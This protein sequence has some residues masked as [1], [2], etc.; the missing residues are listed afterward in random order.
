MSE[1]IRRI[2][3][4]ATL[5]G[6]IAAPSDKSVS[7]RAALFATLYEGVSILTNYSVAEDPQ[8]TLQCIRD[9]GF[10]VETQ[11]QD[12]DGGDTGGV[13]VRITGEGR[14]GWRRRA[15]GRRFELDCGNSGTT[16]R[17]LSGLIAGAGVRCVLTGDASLSRRPM[18][19]ILKPLHDLGASIQAREGRYAPLECISGVKEDSAPS[20]AMDASPLAQEREAPRA[21][22][23]AIASAQ[24][25]SCIL[26]A[27]LFS[28]RGVSVSEPVQSRDHTERMLGI[29][30]QE[31]GALQADSTTS[32]PCQ[33]MRIP[34]DIS[35]AAFWLVAGAV[36][37]DADICVRDCGLN[38]T[39]SGILTV[40]QQ[41]GAELEMDQD[42]TETREPIGSVRVRSSRLKPIHLKGA[43]IPNII[44]E[45]PVIMTA[46]CF[47]D[48]IS[49]ISDAA[50][51][52]VKETDRIAAMCA[53][54]RKA[55]ATI[56]EKP[57]GVVIV[58][59]RDFRP[60]LAP[61]ELFDSEHDHRIAMSCGI[62]SLC[63]GDDGGQIQEGAVGDRGGAETETPRSR[64]EFGILR[65]EAAAV[66]YPEF[67]AHLDSLRA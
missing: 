10:Q 8:S 7:H 53:N 44:D 5:R 66:S 4:A 29:P 41:M 27:G 26:L 59:S 49:E 18:D 46:M 15:D 9:L 47:A 17:M 45:L 42:A 34:G 48:G 14:Q 6:E 65:S 62:L 11:R 31:G 22:P 2:S 60:S 1:T 58:G 20:A 32:I 33:T 61:G 50:E 13:V 12:T 25:K 28:T 23:L 21:F 51:L 16:M 35:S 64:K 37:R 40:L 55:G 56:T 43:I 57:D 38:P 39:R 36:H 19:R 3:P 63:A 67:W 54:L 30:K 52:R 24:V